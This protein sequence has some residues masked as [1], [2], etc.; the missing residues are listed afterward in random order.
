MTRDSIAKTKFYALFSDDLK[1]LSLIELE[2]AIQG[3]L[4]VVVDYYSF[5]ER[6]AGNGRWAHAQRMPSR[7]LNEFIRK[8]GHVRNGNLDCKK[9]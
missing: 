2:W 9:S 6:L 7:S 5:R 8:L 3:A 4:I 1:F